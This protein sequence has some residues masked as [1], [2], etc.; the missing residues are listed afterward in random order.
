MSISN[1]LTWPH[2]GGY[3]RFLR[4]FLNPL[5]VLH[6]HASSSPTIFCSYSSAGEGVG[7][8]AGYLLIG[9]YLLIKIRQQMPGQ[10]KAFIVNRIG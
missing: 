3:Y 10:E 2:E 6:A 4:L 5:H 8:S 1:R 9:F 7:A